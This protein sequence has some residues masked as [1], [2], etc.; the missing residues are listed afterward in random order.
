[1][2][3]K[4]LKYKIEEAIKGSTP[5]KLELIESIL[6]EDHALSMK[7]SR[8]LLYI[9]VFLSVLWFF[10]KYSYVQ[11]LSFIGVELNNTELLLLII[12]LILSILFFRF[13]SNIL[14]CSV[15]SLLLLEVQANI[16]PSFKS[17]SLD[18]VLYQK[19][20][21]NESTILNFLNE[22]GYL[23]KIFLIFQLIMVEMFYLMPFLILLYLSAYLIFFRVFQFDLSITIGLIIFF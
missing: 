23:Y 18:C 17:E 4:N 19:R 16:F 20:F 12:P 7:Q 5:E 21:L 10:I 1:M 2:E 6:R 13:C 15:S 9:F 8:N 11:K 14:S 22:D 3:R